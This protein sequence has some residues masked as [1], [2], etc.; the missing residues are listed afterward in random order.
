MEEIKKLSEKYKK[1][2]EKTGSRR[3]DWND[4]VRENIYNSLE[5][6]R[7]IVDLKW[8]AG[9][10]EIVINHQSVYLSFDKTNSGIVIKSDRS[11]EAKIRHGG[12]LC[13]S[14]IVNGKVV[15]W[16]SYPFVEDLQEQPQIFELL[17]TEMKA[18]IVG[19]CDQQGMRQ[20]IPPQPPRLHHFVY[21][22]SPDEI[23]EFTGSFDYFRT[24]AGIGGTLSDELL[25]AAVQQTCQA[26]QDTSRQTLV[27]VGKEMAR[28]LRDDYDR[29]ESILRRIAL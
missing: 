13:Y 4:S 26:H 29:L 27:R 15:V 3:K 23:R 14:Q 21:P 9:K 10:N 11:S 1:E 5:N 8:Y 7:K 22:C 2:L 24:L 19:Y 20:Q 16:I 12:Y 18:K 17:R 6:I 28:L 25:I